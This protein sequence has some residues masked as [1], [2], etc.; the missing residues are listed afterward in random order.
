VTT[1]LSY[2][3]ITPYRDEAENL[4]RLAPCL[5]SQTATPAAW[6]VLDDGSSD[7]SG[8]F[9]TRLAAEHPWVRPVSSGGGAL[10][11]GAPIVRAFHRGL[12]LLDPMPD[13]V[14]KLDADI[15]MGPDHFEQLLREFERNPRLGIAGGIGY[16]EQADGSWRQR[17]GT[18]EAV[19]GACRAY[20]RECLDH[21]LPLEE[22]MGWDTL[23]LMKA[24]VKGWETRVFYD[25][26]FRHHRG[27]GERDG[28]RLRTTTI[29]GEAAHYMGYRIPYLVLRTLYRL[30]RDPAA[31]GLLVG[32][33][34]ARVR[35]APRCADR[36]LVDYVR[37][38]QS[39]RSLP[40][41]MREARRA[42]EVLVDS[43]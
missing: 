34:R 36:E 33:V 8:A 40:A 23:D 21:I 2:A 43:P 25:L 37:R 9:V 13:V 16:E 4:R 19:W 7:D 5:V 39:F 28:N 1:R 6:V 3:I 29:Q 15:S 11:R 26:S 31:I 38:Q 41:R 30:L 18:G 35:R 12:A 24:N 27:E 32:Y 17:H 42:R 14:V 22:H 10:A 20:R